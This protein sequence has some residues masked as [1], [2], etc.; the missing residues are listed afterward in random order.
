[1]APQIVEVLE[2]L[3]LFGEAEPEHHF[4]WLDIVSLLAESVLPTVGAVFLWCLSVV[5][6]VHS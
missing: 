4:F 6:A 5:C 1:M 2:Q 3:I